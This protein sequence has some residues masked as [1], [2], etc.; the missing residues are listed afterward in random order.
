VDGISWGL[1]V[2]L[3]GVLEKGRWLAWCFCG[4]VVVDCMANVDEKKRLAKD[5]KMGQQF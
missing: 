4:Q 5:R 2:F 1:L 3:R